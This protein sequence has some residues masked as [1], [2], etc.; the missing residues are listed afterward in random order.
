MKPD[1]HPKYQKVVFK[2][3]STGFTFLSGST[4][5]SNE[6]IE[7]ED[8]NNYPLINV[9]VSSDSHPFYTG[10]QKFVDAGG[11]VDRFKKKYNL[12]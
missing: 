12:D 1:I 11:R 8:G 2:D 10:R 6:T 4:M 5:S 7:W 9:E 3:T